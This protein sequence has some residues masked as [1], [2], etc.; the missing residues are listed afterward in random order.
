MARAPP[1]HAA[2][3]VLGGP[4]SAGRVRPTVSSLN[5]CEN[6]YGYDCSRLRLV[7]ILCS[8]LLLLRKPVVLIW[9]CWWCLCDC[10]LQSGHC[11]FLTGQ[12]MQDASQRSGGK[13]AY[14]LGRSLPPSSVHSLLSH[15][16]GLRRLRLIITPLFL[17]LL[18]P[19]LPFV[20]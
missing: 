13:V 17:F 19:V 11:F 16:R 3:P 18:L 12:A 20:L 10:S 8:F 6:G 1:L 14:S 4:C 5:G 7:I 9:E 2:G 15:L